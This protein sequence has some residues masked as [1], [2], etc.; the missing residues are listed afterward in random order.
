MGCLRWGWDRRS[1]CKLTVQGEVCATTSAAGIFKDLNSSGEHAGNAELEFVAVRSQA[2]V[3][4]VF[5]DVRPCNHM[6]AV[7]P[8]ALYLQGLRLIFILQLVWDTGSKPFD[9]PFAWACPGD[10]QRVAERKD[11]VGLGILRDGRQHDCWR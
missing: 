7:N 4:R 6:T 5:P 2:L 3:V 11:A 9:Q 10:G 8:S 1:A